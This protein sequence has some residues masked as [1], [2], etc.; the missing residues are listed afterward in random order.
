[1]EA[2][3]GGMTLRQYAAI[4][5][6][7]PDSGDAWL[8]AMIRKA[9]ADRFAGQTIHAILREAWCDYEADGDTLRVAAKQAYDV[10]D[11]MIAERER[12]EGGKA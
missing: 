1:M 12:R 11:A 9:L 7:V 2:G 4:K 10:A 5:L 3:Y 8:N 6:C